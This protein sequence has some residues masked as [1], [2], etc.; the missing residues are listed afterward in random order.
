MLL[1]HWGK[2][3][4]FNYLQFFSFVR[5]LD[6]VLSIHNQ[7]CQCSEFTDLKGKHW[8]KAVASAQNT[9]QYLSIWNVNKSI[10]M[11]RLLENSQ[12]SLDDQKNRWHYYWLHILLL[13]V[14]QWMSFCHYPHLSW[15]LEPFLFA[16]LSWVR[17][18]SNFPPVKVGLS[19]LIL[20]Q[21]LLRQIHFH[22]IQEFQ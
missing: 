11:I 16:H 22:G 10:K 15:D 6:V 14:S 13:H 3:K 1:K 17:V 12:E 4:T 20:G 2:Q 21:V 19:C 9:T 5:I 8:L 18:K 7:L